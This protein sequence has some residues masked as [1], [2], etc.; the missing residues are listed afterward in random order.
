M[1]AATITIRA[2]QDAVQNALDDPNM[3]SQTFDKDAEDVRF[4]LL[5]APG[6][7]GIEVHASSPSLGQKEMKGGLRK[8]R[9]LLE[10]GEIPTGDR[11]R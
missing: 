7:R 4:S 6:E 8:Y 2:A 3:R 10:A 9:S 1:K 5:E 11:R